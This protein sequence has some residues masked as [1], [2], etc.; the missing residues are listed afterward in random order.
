LQDGG[1]VTTLINTEQQW[2]WPN[3]WAP[4]QWIA[5]KG[6]DNYGEKGLAAE[7]AHHWA[8]LNIKVLPQ[9]R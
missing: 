7:S 8:H 1:V 6:L 4:L 2:D 3:G 9:Y 5:I